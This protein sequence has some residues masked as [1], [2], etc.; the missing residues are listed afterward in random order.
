MEQVE[1]LEHAD[2][3]QKLSTNLMTFKAILLD[4]EGTTT[5]IDFVHKTL[6]PFAKARIAGFVQEHFDELRF[7]VGQLATEHAA[8]PDYARELRIDSPNSIA[9]YLK[10]LIEDDRKST[11]LKTIQG[12]IWEKGYESG[13]L[14]SN[15]FAD[16]P[17]A[18][19]RWKDAGISIA[20]YSSGSV[21]AQRLIFKYSDQGD[22]APFIDKY[23]DT[24]TGPKCEADSYRKIAE[25]LEL[26]GNEIMFVSDVVA[27][28]EAARTAGMQTA[29]SIRKGNAEITEDHSYRAIQGLEGLD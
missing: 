25:E 22:L 3:A 14:V 8:D 9:D 19:K 20:I 18:F 28:L 29:L 13:G 15:V 1:R 17:A 10:Y 26:K 27:E 2:L 4:I 7:E 11:P 23:F 21:L 12:M 5:P 16:V 6:F 24:N